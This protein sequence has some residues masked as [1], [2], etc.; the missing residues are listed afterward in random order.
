MP[1][2][3]DGIPTMARPASGGRSRSSRSAASSINA[4]GANSS[5]FKSGGIDLRQPRH[6]GNSALSH[7][8]KV[9]GV[10]QA[11]YFSSDGLAASE[12]ESQNVCTPV[13]T[14]PLL[15][16]SNKLPMAGMR[17]PCVQAAR[18]GTRPGDLGPAAEWRALVISSPIRT[19]VI[20]VSAVALGPCGP[21][22]PVLRRAEFYKPST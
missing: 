17:A 12:E 13:L 11:L 15:R 14:R 6:Q 1:S 21:S 22:R 19:S 4:D 2:G 16:F 20:T 8:G 9:K 10:L 18:A 5:A 7:Q 3:P